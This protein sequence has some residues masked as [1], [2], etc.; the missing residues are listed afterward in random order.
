MRENNSKELKEF[1]FAGK[2]ADDLHIQPQSFCLGM[3]VEGWGS[4]CS[5]NPPG[6]IQCWERE[7]NDKPAF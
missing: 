6:L 7:T 1:F 5:L 3:G 4:E 2:G